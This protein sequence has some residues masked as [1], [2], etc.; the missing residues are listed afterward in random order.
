[1]LEAY[2]K[3]TFYRDF[4]KHTD[5]PGSA[6]PKKYSYL[7]VDT[8][9]VRHEGWTQRRAVYV[10]D[11]ADAVIL[12]EKIAESPRERMMVILLNK[13]NGVI[14]IQEATIGNSEEV[15]SEAREMFQAAIAV[16]ASKIVLLHNHPAPTPK[17]SQG[18]LDVAKTLEQ[19]GEL[20]GI[21]LVDFII[22]TP[23]EFYSFADTGLIKPDA[24]EH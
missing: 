7:Q 9:L 4:E 15:H 16:N 17:P 24:T 10:N 22:V 20:I 5:N 14:G 11:P 2:S 6:I 8:K 1:M 13:K 3:N 21:K 19:A 23:E 12:V 18:D